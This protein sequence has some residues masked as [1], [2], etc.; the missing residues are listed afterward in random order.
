MN[1]ERGL[2][3]GHHH[4]RFDID[5]ESLTL[6]VALMTAALADYLIAE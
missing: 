3:F 6:G 5:E 2:N 1:E 4:P